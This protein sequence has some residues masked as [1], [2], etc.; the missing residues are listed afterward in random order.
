MWEGGIGGAGG[1]RHWYEVVRR[2]EGG[3]GQMALSLNPRYYRCAVSWIVSV[4]GRLVRERVRLIE[5]GTRATLP[6]LR[7][8]T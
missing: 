2:G 6:S 8:S 4:L 1:G 7:V 3:I 5:I